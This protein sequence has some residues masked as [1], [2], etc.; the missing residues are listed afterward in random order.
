MSYKRQFQAH[1]RNFEYALR[2][3]TL[4][5]W[6]TSMACRGVLLVSVIVLSVAYIARV[7]SAS[8]T[9][10]QMHDLEKQVM[11]LNTDVQNMEIQIAD[12]GSMNNT[13]KRLATLN[14]VKAEN[15]QYLAKTV[16]TVAKR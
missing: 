11:A 1:Y 13:E 9:G 10:F 15:V 5:S 3:I 8:T 16:A 7:N 14:M 2:T 4:P 12:A 6:L